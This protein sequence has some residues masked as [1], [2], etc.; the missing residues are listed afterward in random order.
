MAARHFWLALAL[1]AQAA[2]LQAQI[3]VSANDGKARPADAPDA[4]RTAD[5]IAVLNLGARPV[6]TLAT[7]PVPATLVG[8]PSSVTLSRDSRLAIVTA[9][10]SL[11]AAGAAVPADTVTV[12]DLGRPAAPRVIQT[13]HAGT[14]AAGVAINPAGTVALVANTGADSVSIFAIA[15]RT[16]SSVGT[17]ALDP[18]SRPVDVAFAGDG[19]A[20]YVVAQGANRL[21]RLAIDG[22]R[23][24]RAGGDIAL[25]AQP[26]SL[27]LNRK[28]H[29]AY[30]THLGGRVSSAAPGPK[31]GSVGIVDLRAGRMVGQVDTGVTPEHVG[32]S[33]SG[34]FLE[35]TVNNGTTAPANSSAFRDHGLMIIYRASGAELTPVAHA[36]TGRWCQG[37]AWSEDEKLVYLQCSALKQI[38]VYR[39]DGHALTR[40][41]AAT[42]QLDARPGAIATAR[43]R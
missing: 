32:L 30:V 5:S 42:I 13:L 7:L 23:V 41:S 38:E 25:G 39:F 22:Q 9:G 4:P 31:P 35:V 15:G 8:P 27:A 2:S 11:D 36:D 18:R 40:D 28:T 19:R 33:P 16:L 37:A 34:H 20:A 14:G 1:V 24:T 21:V 26:Y 10:Q 29:M 6:R 17:V 12:I 43:S 3:A